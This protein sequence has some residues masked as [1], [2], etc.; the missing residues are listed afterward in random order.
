MLTDKEIRDHLKFLKQKHDVKVY[1][2]L[3]Y[4]KGLK[5]K[6]DIET[7][8]KRIVKGVESD[9][10]YKPFKTNVGIKTRPSSY[11][12]RFKKIF[13]GAESL[14]EKAKATGVPLNIIKKVY[15]KGLAAWR[16]GHRPGATPQQWGYARVHS[17]LVMGRTTRGPDKEL[18]E[19][20]KE[21]M[22]P[23]LFKRWS[24]RVM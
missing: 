18:L 1:T 15:N 22:S 16:T 21:R 10:Y 23:Q 14:E 13:P 19:E 7:R 17:F 24:N 2:P 8:F 5:T 20:A 12:S 6:K 9:N 11:T 4:F 3:K